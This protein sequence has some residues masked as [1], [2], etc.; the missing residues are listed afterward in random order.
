MFMFSL[1]EY[2]D[3][4]LLSSSIEFIFLYVKKKIAKL[5]LK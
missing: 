4:E 3:V 5:F 1:G 2:L